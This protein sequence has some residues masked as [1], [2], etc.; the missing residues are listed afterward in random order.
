MAVSF[1]NGYIADTPATAT[2]QVRVSVPNLT[3][4]DRI[5]YGP[6]PWKPQIDENNVAHGPSRGDKALIAIDDANPGEQWIVSWTGTRVIRVAT[7][8]VTGVNI[9]GIGIAG[10]K[11]AGRKLAVADFT[12]LLGLSTPIG[13]FPMDSVNNLGSAGTALTNKGGIGFG[14]GITGDPAEAAQFAGNA[15]QAF[16]IADTGVN[17]PFRLRTG[18]VGGWFKT[19]KLATSQAVV[20]KMSS[21]AGNFGYMLNVT[22]GS[23]LAGANSLRWQLSL[24]G[25]TMNVLSGYS[26]VCD[27]QWHFG[28]GTFDGE[29]MR[30]YVDAIMET[31]YTVQGVI[32]SGTGPFNVGSYGSDG[33]TNATMPQFGKVQSAFATQDILNED[34][35]RLLMAATVP[36]GLTSTPDEV[37][38]S[39]RRYRRNGA[40]SAASFPTAPLRLH[41]FTNGSLSDSG[42]NGTA[43]AVASGTPIQAAGTDGTAKNAYAMNNGWFSA[44]DTGLPISGA[45]SWGAWVTCGAIGATSRGIM[46][47]G[48]TTLLR[49]LYVGGSGGQIVMNGNG[50]QL[51]STPRAD[52]ALMRL[53]VAVYN[54]AA[55]DGL[56]MK[57]YFDSLLVASSTTTLSNAALAGAG[58]LVVGNLRQNNVYQANLL[59]DSPFICGYALTHAQIVAL[60]AIPGPALAGPSPLPQSIVEAADATNLYVLA[61]GIEPQHQIDFKAVAA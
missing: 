43:L 4:Q 24:D 53:I 13:L 36:H 2:D 18:S 5:V 19:A 10:S 39:V 59:I 47:W 30:L 9:N 48:T 58:G 56:F 51:V 34:Q 44:S 21:A 15:A 17:D 50:G 11:R 3:I 52:D 49:E 6:L 8:K 29:A 37:H 40:Q 45:M 54:P 33:A 46:G 31:S 38:T 23:G 60:A 55:A 32:F 16:Y 57:L 28:V 35:I 25:S 61:N 14:S 27:D 22:A 41:N 7:N 42:S 1:Y 20:S 26:D 12:T